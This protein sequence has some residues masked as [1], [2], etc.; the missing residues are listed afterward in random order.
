M[1]MIDGASGLRSVMAIQTPRLL[2]KGQGRRGRLPPV[3]HRQ[4]YLAP[5]GGD[6]ALIR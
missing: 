3:Q 4:P 1:G 2:D 6:S 5:D